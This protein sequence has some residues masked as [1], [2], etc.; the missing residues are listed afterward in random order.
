MK[1]KAMGHPRFSN[2]EIVRRG[3]ERYEKEL[4]PK[5]ETEGNLGKIVVVGIET[6]DYEIDDD[7]LKA[8][9]AVLSRHPGAAICAARIGYDAVSD[10]AG[11]PSPV[12][13]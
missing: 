7:A 5:I 6:G 11:G 1:G 9:R 4:R 8:S 10:F 13:A 12:K 2:E 3:E